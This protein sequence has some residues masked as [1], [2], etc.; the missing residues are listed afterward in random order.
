MEYRPLGRTGLLVSEIGLGCEGFMEKEEAQAV[1]ELSYAMEQGINFMD[2]YSPNP[3][4]RRNVAAALR[5]SRNKMILQ[6]H[7]CTAWEDGQYLRTRDPEKVRSSFEISLKEL[8]TD[9][10]DI[11]MIHYVDSM[12]DWN[13]VRDNGI[14]DYAVSLKQKGVIGH[15]GL[16][17]HNPVVARAAVESG[18]LE[19]LLFAINPC[20][21]MQPPSEDVED[22]WADEHYAHALHNHDADR[23]A[24]YELCEKMGV[25]ID[26]MK[27]FGGGDLLSAQLSPFGR[28]F[29]PVQCLHYALTRPGVASVMAGCRTLAELD[30][31][32]AYLTASPEEKDYAPV[33][34]GMEQFT[35]SGHCMYCGHCA[36]CPMEIDVAYVTKYLNLCLAQNSVPETVAD[37]YRLLEHHAGECISCG[38][39]ESNC[40]FGVPIME[41][42]KK[43]AEVFGF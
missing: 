9:F 34:A 17:S 24:L 28:A 43:A 10:I 36:P 40:P 2:L 5:G 7:L 25:G 35:F 39:C 30:A 18:V 27:A 42:M 1:Q 4:L 29:T 37:H 41:N 38:R 21:D 6:N 19:V 31:S 12:E 16:S 20:Y 8:G 11:G 13:R 23:V 26:V 14:L 3:V 22:L 33:L 32:L 15:I